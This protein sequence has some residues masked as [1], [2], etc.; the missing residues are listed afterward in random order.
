MKPPVTSKLAILA[1][2]IVCVSHSGRALETEDYKINQSSV[3]HSKP[4]AFSIS[5]PKGWT[6][7]ETSRPPQGEFL[8][9][10]DEHICSFW[11]KTS[12]SNWASIDV[13]RS[14]GM[15]AGD[16]RERFAKSV[17]QQN[18]AYSHKTLKAIKTKQ[19]DEG[20]VAVFEANFKQGE[21]TL[22]N[23]FFHVGTKRNNSYFS[24]DQS[25]RLCFA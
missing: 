23:Y 10:D 1:C 24:H 4:V 9:V 21:A 8:T 14:S 7:I 22:S 13:W 6:K 15:T 12:I 19:G 3:S 20:F 16:E 2:I 11:S 5:F 18:S 17:L 25:G